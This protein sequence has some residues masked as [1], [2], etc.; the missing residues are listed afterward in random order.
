MS[1]HRVLPRPSALSNE[2][3]ATRWAAGADSLKSARIM[4]N[5][6]SN[7]AYL[8][9]GQIPASSTADS[10]PQ[11]SFITTP[12]PEN[13][14]AISSPEHRE[15]VPEQDNRDPAPARVRK[16]APSNIDTWQGETP[17]QICLCQ[18]DPKVPRPRNG[19][20]DLLEIEL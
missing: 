4:T 17:S 18:P 1:Y 10:D 9:N 16:S 7:S 6:R 13:Q 14:D 5:E 2:D 20:N 15:S 19:M 11:K 12:E 3:L 8:K